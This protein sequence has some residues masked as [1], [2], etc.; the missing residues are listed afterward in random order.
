MRRLVRSILVLS[1]VVVLNAPVASARPVNDDQNP[2]AVSRI[3]KV[4]RQIVRLIVKPLGD[5]GELLPPKP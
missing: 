1:F 4:V 5:G 3:V 2:G